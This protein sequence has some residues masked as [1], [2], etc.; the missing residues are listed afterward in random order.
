MRGSFSAF[1]AARRQRDVAQ[2]AVWCAAAVGK[3]D[4]VI[5]KRSAIPIAKDDGSAV[6]PVPSSQIEIDIAMRILKYNRRIVAA[7][8]HFHAPEGSPLAIYG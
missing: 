8:T 7:K 1:Q 3:R 2:A 4:P 6:D 5:G